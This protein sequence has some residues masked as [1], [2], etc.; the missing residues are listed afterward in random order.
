M[1]SNNL[2]EFKNFFS[3]GGRMRLDGISHDLIHTLTPSE[4]TQAYDFLINGDFLRIGREIVTSLFLL[5]SKRALVDIQEEKKIQMLSEEGK[6]QFLL[7]KYRQDNDSRFYVKDLM[8]YLKSN[9]KDA[10][11]LALY[12]LPTEGIGRD[13]LLELTDY[14]AKE[15][16]DLPYI[17]GIQKILEMLGLDSESKEYKESYIYLR[18]NRDSC[19]KYLTQ[20][21]CNT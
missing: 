18:K 17:K 7:E 9:E 5:D 13:E 21:I 1:D 2:K 10:R 16:E 20:M 15:S 19:K 6:I 14:L 4:K 11:T 8:S 12:Y 3:I